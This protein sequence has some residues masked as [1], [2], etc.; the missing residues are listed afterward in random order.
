MNRK[1]DQKDNAIQQAANTFELKNFL[2]M[3]PII[4]VLKD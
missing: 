1:R 4:A 2:D 3:T